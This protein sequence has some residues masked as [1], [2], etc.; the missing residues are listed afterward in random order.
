MALALCLPRNVGISILPHLRAR[1]VA[2][3][4]YLRLFSGA[5]NSYGENAC[6]WRLA[7]RL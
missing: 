6:S 4:Q 3:G 7:R 5:V 2:V 1:L